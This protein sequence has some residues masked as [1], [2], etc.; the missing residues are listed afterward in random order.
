MIDGVHERIR[1]S[2]P[3]IRTTSTSAADAIP[4]GS[5]VRGLDCPFT[6][7]ASANRCCPS[8]LYTFPAVAGLARDWLATDVA[9]AFPDFEQIH[10]AV[11]VRSAQFCRNPVLF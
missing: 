10:Y 3:R 2:D 6:L 7:G 9:L 5:I 8:S 11:S 1:T 4:E